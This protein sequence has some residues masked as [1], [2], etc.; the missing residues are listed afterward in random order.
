VLDS[1]EPEWLRNS[2]AAIFAAVGGIIGFQ[3]KQDRRL[4]KVEQQ[5]EDVSVNAQKSAELG[6]RMASVEAKVDSLKGSLER[7][8]QNLIQAL[9]S[10]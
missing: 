4:T 2:I 6:E 7:I 1:L 9:K 5:V 3:F 8:D 10:R